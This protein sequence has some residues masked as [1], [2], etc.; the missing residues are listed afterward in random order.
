MAR[1]SQ[2]KKTEV[3]LSPDTKSTEVPDAEFKRE[4]TKSPNFF[5]VYANDIQVQT[6][7]WDIRFVL[8]EM[9]DVSPDPATVNVRQVGELRIS[10]QLAKHLAMIILGQL[11]EYERRFGEI[12]AIKS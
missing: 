2:S 12:P 10:P 7:P 5:S 6:S 3:T 9:G 11:R 4:V 1:K 8:G